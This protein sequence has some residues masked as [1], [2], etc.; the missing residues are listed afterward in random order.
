MGTDEQL[1]VEAK[2]NFHRVEMSEEMK[3][4]A[5]EYVLEAFKEN[6]IEKDVATSVKRKF[7]ETQGPTWY[8][9]VGKG[10]GCSVAHDTQHLLFL[11]V[12]QTFVLIFKS[13]DV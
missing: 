8:C 9:I 13:V 12:D 3:E 6:K 10:F 11:Q 1:E 4:K 2:V 5:L 7:D